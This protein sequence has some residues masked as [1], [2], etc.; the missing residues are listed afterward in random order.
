MTIHID[1][2][3]YIEIAN[4]YEREKLQFE[5]IV[6]LFNNDNHASLRGRDLFLYKNPKKLNHVKIL[7]MPYLHILS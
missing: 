4:V 1:E 6:S 5:F 2:D 3:R 7:H